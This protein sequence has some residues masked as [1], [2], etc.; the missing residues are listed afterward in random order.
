VR[1]LTPMRVLTK[2]DGPVLF[3]TACRLA[4]YGSLQTFIAEH[5]VT[6]LYRTAAG[7]YSRQ[8]PEVMAMNAAWRGALDGLVQLGLT[9]SARSRV[10]VTSSPNQADELE[11][12]L[13]R[14]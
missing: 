2:A 14:R 7:E 5:G 6:Y 13:A 9:P 12:Y 1:S 8:R 10:S 11:T 3:L 4:E